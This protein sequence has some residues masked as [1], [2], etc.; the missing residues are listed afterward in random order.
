MK[1][2]GADVQQ[3]VNAAGVTIDYTTLYGLNA[4]G[5]LWEQAWIQ[6]MHLTGTNPAYERSPDLSVG[7]GQ[8]MSV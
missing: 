6:A 2:G 1:E 4:I 7:K 3:L 5:C 8:K